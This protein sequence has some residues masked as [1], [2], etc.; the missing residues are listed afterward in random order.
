MI[1]IIEYILITEY[2]G[3]PI[4]HIPI[5]MIIRGFDVLISLADPF[6]TKDTPYLFPVNHPCPIRDPLWGILLLFA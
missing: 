6:K 3:I 1:I 4:P 2:S 5:L